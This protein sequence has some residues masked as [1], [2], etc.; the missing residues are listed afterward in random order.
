LPPKNLWDKLPKL[1]FL[2]YQIQNSK[3]KKKK[4][5]KKTQKNQKKIVSP[6]FIV[7]PLIKTTNAHIMIIGLGKINKIYALYNKEGIKKKKKRIKKKV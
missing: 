4:K 7:P 2:L 6:K 1:I 5:K 3:K